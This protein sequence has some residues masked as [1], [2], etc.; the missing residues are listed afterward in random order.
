MSVQTFR[1]PRWLA[2]ALI[3]LSVLLVTGLVIVP[4]NMALPGWLFAGMFLA[5]PAVIG[6]S[7]LRYRIVVDEAAVEVI[8]FK[9]QRFLLSDAAGIAIAR[10]NKGGKVATVSFKDGHHWRF[11][12]TLDR[13][14]VLL[15]LLSQRTSLPIARPVWDPDILGDASKKVA[16]RA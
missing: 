14:R 10:G 4:N 1:Y 8:G 12:D 7:A 6:W 3:A 16:K 13:F 15:D 5:T 2:W 9:R 11:D